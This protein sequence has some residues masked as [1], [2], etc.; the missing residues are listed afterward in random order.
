VFNCLS[1]YV[2]DNVCGLDGRSMVRFYAHHLQL[3]C[4]YLSYLFSFIVSIQNILKFII[5]WNKVLI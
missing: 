2:G 3:F 1:E 4:I 5:L